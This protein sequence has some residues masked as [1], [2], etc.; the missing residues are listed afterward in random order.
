MNTII[1]T[2]LAIA[3]LS[4]FENANA[5][6][7]YHV[8]VDSKGLSGLGFLDLQFNPGNDG[9]TAAAARISNFSGLLDNSV[10]PQFFGSVSGA[11]PGSLKFAN[12]GSY[13]DVFQGVQLGGKFS[14][15]ISFS[16]DFFNNPGDVGSAFALSMYAADGATALG[17]GDVN[18]ASLLTFD[19]APSSNGSYG[20][21]NTM[22]FDNAMISLSPVPEPS[23]WAMM[24]GGLLALG[25]IA[26]RRQKQ[27]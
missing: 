15:N 1:K 7:Q 26:R 16:G 10:A 22:V 14:F 17:N 4:A 5:D 9:A 2:L 27:A 18:T 13:N 21:V 12:S 20:V 3:L 23:Q 24:A 8:V 25:A 11:L 19:L 6:T